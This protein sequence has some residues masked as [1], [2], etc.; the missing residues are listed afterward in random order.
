MNDKMFEFWL[1]QLPQETNFMDENIKIKVS[2]YVCRFNLQP[3]NLFHGPLL[4]FGRIGTHYW[5]LMSSLLMVW[6]HWDVDVREHYNG[7]CFHGTGLDFFPG[8]R[9]TN[10]P[11]NDGPRYISE[12]SE[13]QKIIKTVINH[14]TCC[15]LIQTK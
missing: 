7:R 14:A 4:M 12:N 10:S 6:C 9:P 13:H 5:L 8:S 3:Q 11:L 2:K 1:E 15:G